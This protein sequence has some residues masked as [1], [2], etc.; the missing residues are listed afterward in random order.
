MTDGRVAVIAVHQKIAVSS[1]I[2]QCDRNN[3]GDDN[4]VISAQIEQCDRNSDGDDNSVISGST[5]VV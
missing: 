3:D 4:S 5:V 2:E 1:Q